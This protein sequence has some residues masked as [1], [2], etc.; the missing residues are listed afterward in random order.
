MRK[1]GVTVAA[2]LMVWMVGC[3]GAEGGA[4]GEASAGRTADATVTV[5]ASGRTSD[6]TATVPAPWSGLSPSGFAVRLTPQPDP[7]VVGPVHFV[8]VVTGEGRPTSADLV[9]PT[10]QMHGVVRYPVISDDAG[11]RVEVEIPMEGDWALYINFGD[12][13]E[14]AEI[15]FTVAAADSAV[16]HHHH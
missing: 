3:S 6:A 10:M 4:I 1:A 2:A 14:S 16:V 15:L 13:A 12:G 9:S 11:H 5:P 8:I 7:P